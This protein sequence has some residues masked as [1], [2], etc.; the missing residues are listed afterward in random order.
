MS[1]ASNTIVGVI[2]GLAAGFVLGVLFAPEKGSSTRGDM[3]FNMEYFGEVLKKKLS[4]M[5]ADIIDVIS[6]VEENKRAV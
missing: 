4:E 1:K 2:S 3:A 6:P 5:K